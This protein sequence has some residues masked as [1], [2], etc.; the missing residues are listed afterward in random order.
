MKNSENEVEFVDFQKCDSS[1][2][3]KGSDLFCVSCKK[4]L[5]RFHK[6]L[7]VQCEQPV[8]KE[9]YLKDLC[10]LVRPWGKTKEEN[11][12]KFYG[13]KLVD[14]K[15]MDVIAGH[16]ITDDGEEVRET[17]C[18]NIRKDLLKRSVEFCVDNFDATFTVLVFY[19]EIFAKCFP[20]IAKYVD[21]EETRLKFVDFMKNIAESNIRLFAYIAVFSEDRNDLI[22]MTEETIRKSGYFLRDLIGLSL[23]LKG[24]PLFDCL[25]NRELLDWS[26]VEHEDY[27]FVEHIDG[28]KW[29]ESNG[30]DVV[31]DEEHFERFARYA[32]K[33]VKEY[34]VSKGGKMMEYLISD[35]FIYSDD[36]E[37]IHNFNG[38]KGIENIEVGKIG[39]YFKEVKYLK[40][41]GYKFGKE[42]ILLTTR[43]VDEYY[44]L[45][46]LNVLKYKKK[47]KGCCKITLRPTTSKHANKCIHL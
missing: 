29:I 15:G 36:L 3:G 42:K 8:C 20:R 47:E 44:A 46:C 7:C 16:M 28:M 41:I 1:D 2:C 18:S 9:C 13:N 40:S 6:I 30:I 17:K 12:K 25:K 37:I 10:C 27:L 38:L 33:E 43:D 32:S 23:R 19:E 21:D 5:C 14:V 35:D 11:L 31:N 4:W 22:S 39:F 34:L 24:K 45:L 26:K